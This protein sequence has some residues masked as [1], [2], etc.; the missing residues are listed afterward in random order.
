MTENDLSQLR[1]DKSGIP[2]RSF[3]RKRYVLLVFLVG[4]LIATGFLYKKGVLTPATQVQIASVQKIYPSQTFTILNA[5]GYVVAQRKA[6][7]ATKITG[8]IVYLAVEEGSRIKK[9]D[10]I[11]R[12]ENEDTLAVKNQAMASVQTAR[13]QL[14]QSLAELSDATLSYNRSKELV[15]AG[16]IAKAEF[17]SADA[18]FKRAR[19]AVQANQSMVSNSQAA[20]QGAEVT[21][22]YANLRAPFD[23]VVLTKNADIG[24]I[25]TPLGAAANAKAAV[26]DVADMDSLKVEVDV[27][28]SNIEKVFKDQPCEIHLDALPSER[29]PGKVH[30]IVPTADRTKASVMVKVAFNALS[31]KVLPEMSAKVAF[32][33]REITEAEMQPITAVPTSVIAYRNNQPVA[34]R[35]SGDR[36]AIAPVVPGRQ[37]NGMNEILSGLNIGDKVVISPTETIIEGT[38]IKLAQ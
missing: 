15:S 21:L 29:F 26:V 7:V 22:D 18:R 8:R 9:G 36:A 37:M 16:Y 33:L 30:M 25:V 6:A 12:L 14:E 2:N 20:L 23:A 5:S 34:F 31:P 11:A 1:I 19:A 3:K 24:D 17:D 32:L 35:I 27:S 38:R 28:E 10:I 13:F 4:L